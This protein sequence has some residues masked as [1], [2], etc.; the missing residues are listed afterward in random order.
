MSLLFAAVFSVVSSTFA[1]GAPLP[2]RTAAHDCGG[3]NRSPELHWR[4][5]PKGTRSFAVIMHDPDAPVPGGFYHWELYNV[6]AS[7]T[8]LAEAHNGGGY[9]G[10]CP[11]SGRHHYTITVYA[12]DI[13][14]IA[15]SGHL[16]PP[17]LLAKMN[18]HILSRATIM[19]TYDA[20]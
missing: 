6:P 19:G 16:N 10:P 12:L 15:G 14:A 17:G 2:A 11:P 8:H 4:N 18:G 9:Y 13:A 7:T 1:A 20:R 3:E 5:A